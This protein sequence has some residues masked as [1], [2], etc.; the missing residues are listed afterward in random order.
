MVHSRFVRLFMV[1]LVL[2]VF[3]GASS[4]SAWEFSMEGEV[5]WKNRFVGQL[6]SN[7]FFGKYDSDN[8]STPGNFASVNG[9]VSGKLNDLSSSSS[10]AD[11]VMETNV[12][13]ELRLNPAMRLRGEYRIGSFGD[14]TASSYT[15]STRPGVQVAISEGQWTMWWFSAQTPWGIV[16][17]GKRPF[18]FG[19]GL[20]YNGAEDLTSESLLLIAPTGPFRIGIGFYP[21]RQQP[22]NP[23]RQNQPNNSIA[24]TPDNPYFNPLDTNAAL[25]VSPTAFLTYE[26]GPLSVGIVAE[27]FSYHRGPES[28]RVQTERV[29]FPTSDIVSTDGGIFV[30]YFN[31]RY[32]FNAELDWVNKTT[33][34]QRSQDG[35]FVGTLDRTDGTGS[36]FAPRYIEAWRWM[37]ETG[38]MAGPAKASFMYAWLP[39]PDRRQGV[40][41]DRQPYFYGFANHGLFIPYTLVMNFYYGAGLNL[42]NLNTDGYMNDASIFAGRLD[43]AVASNLNVFSSFCWAD[44]ASGAG[45]G[46]GFI[47]PA[48]TGSTVQFQNLSTINAARTDAPSIPDNS[49]GWEIDAGIDWLLLDKWTVKMAAGYWQ[50][51]KWFNYACIDKTVPNW[52]NPSR[53]NQFGINPNRVI[54]PIMAIR[55]LVTVEF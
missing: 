14:P 48:A 25:A 28:Q 31:G 40:L 5:V 29:A 37:V 20:Q 1:T 52:D 3:L 13:T 4:S 26:A 7:G 50:P 19:C 6:G 45:Y 2:S 49:L 54:D 18:K 43:Y 11:Q 23:F 36:L 10:A 35:T 17:Y 34:F 21:W 44:R 41:I 51:G 46:W 39:G 12:L 16:V 22:D 32:F 55:I 33:K 53:A 9:W 27:Y 30:K 24:Q 38:F 47:R 15:N 8:S 42:Y